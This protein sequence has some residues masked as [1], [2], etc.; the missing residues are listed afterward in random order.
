MTLWITLR[1]LRTRWLATLITLLAVALAT[2]T[3][4]VVPLLTRQV[5]RGAQDAAQVFDLLIT[6]KGSASQAVLSSLFY[7]DVPI[8]NLP[9]SEYARLKADPRTRR[10]VMLGFGDNYH[11]LPVVGT[12]TR[13]FDQR[14]KPNDPPYFRVAQGKLFGKVYDAVLGQTAQRQTGLKLGDTFKSAHGLED[15]SAKGVESEEH[16]ATYTV[17]GI[18]APTGGPIDRAVV[19]PIE[20]LWQI[21]G[22]LSPESRGVTAVLY[23]ANAL[24]DLYSVAQQT[25][26]RPDAQAVFPGQVFAQLRGFILQGQ[27]AY[28][29][30]SL[31][32]LLLAGLTVWLSVHSA[33]LERARSVALLRALGGGRGTVFG[34][35][36]LETALVVLLGLL[37]GVLLSLGLGQL[38]GGVLGARLGFSLPAP[39]LDPALLWRVLW[40]FPLGLLAALPPAISAARA[41][42][43]RN[44]A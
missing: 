19:T 28:A 17:V 30:L 34:V 1:N 31:L 24:N 37:L 35:V 44:L 22:Q 13:F 12:E 2:A 27:A 36:L 32:M 3:A 38:A 16:N 9:Y 4:L 20:S 7:L 10:A 21:H 43:T 5:E 14:L 26:A 25:N 33:G 11:G 40:L 29:G 41:E 42:P 18:L 23:T 6:A 39:T 15:L 8:G